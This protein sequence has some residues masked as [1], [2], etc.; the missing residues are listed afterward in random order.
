M[1][2]DYTATIATTGTVAVGGRASGEIEARKDVDWFSVTLEAGRT[3]VIDVDRSGDNPLGRALLK[4]VYD[5]DGGRVRGFRA[6]AD[7]E[8]GS[9][10]E[11]E[12]AES[13]TYYIAAT[14]KGRQ[15]GEYTVSVT[16]VSDPDAT[17]AGAY[18]LGSVW[19]DSERT[20]SWVLDGWGVEVNGEI[21]VTDYYKFTTPSRQK[22]EFRLKGQDFDADLYLEDAA[23]N[24]LDSS[25]RTGTRTEKVGAELDAGTYYVRVVAQEKGKNDYKLVYSAEYKGGDAD[26]LVWEGA[27]EPAA[28]LN[29]MQDR[30]GIPDDQ[31]V[32]PD[33]SAAAK[34]AV[35]GSVTGELKNGEMRDWIAVDMKGGTAYRIDLKGKSTGN[36]TL[37][38]PM[39]D[40]VYD[41]KG[42]LYYSLWGHKVRD[43]G[44]GTNDRAVF[45]PGEDGTYYFD[46]SAY[47]GTE[48]T[49]T[50]TVT[51]THESDD[52]AAGL[53]CCW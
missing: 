9:R 21:D 6:V 17:R 20:N 43:S 49:G 48:P 10:L 51:V 11:F 1:P 35:G 8:G 34:V 5:D 30:E 22:V 39:L 36:G 52:Y 41:S 25:T 13:G 38:D 24:V 23:G 16:D 31:R 7:G 18:D 40:D 4:G 19:S 42:N 47:F 53:C 28:R 15:T 14:G 26:Y 27:K 29:P 12:A 45:T 3:Y 32:T 50:Y 46:V 2:D 44:T 37:I 33:K